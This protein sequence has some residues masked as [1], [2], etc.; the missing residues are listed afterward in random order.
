MTTAL[1]LFSDVLQQE[2]REVVGWREDFLGS[3]YG[4]KGEPWLGV[5]QL[6]SK[7]ISCGG[8]KYC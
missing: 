4:A 8:G 1:G 6:M 2:G 7:A 5:D 3:D